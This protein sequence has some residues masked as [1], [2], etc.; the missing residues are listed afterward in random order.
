MQRNKFTK[1][2]LY[3]AILTTVVVATWVFT[4]VWYSFT[5]S[6][7]PPETNKYATPID[8]SFDIGTM[9]M[10]NQRLSVPVNLTEQGDYIEDPR[11]IPQQSTQSADLTEDEESVPDIEIVDISIS[12][13]E[14]PSGESL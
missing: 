3:I 13:V 4:S 2:I 11:E 6:T 12:P 7:T 14:T 9:D 1:N 10:L 5:K 8:P